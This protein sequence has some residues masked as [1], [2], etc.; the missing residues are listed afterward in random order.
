MRDG[1]EGAACSCARVFAHVVG[2]ARGSPVRV[3]TRVTCVVCICR[4]WCAMPC[5]AVPRAGMQPAGSRQTGADVA[6]CGRAAWW[7]LMREHIKM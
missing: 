1:R 3:V 2:T 7:C 6:L 4:V 5:R